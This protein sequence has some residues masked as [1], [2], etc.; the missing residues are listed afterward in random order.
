MHLND[1]GVAEKKEVWSNGFLVVEEY[2]DK[3][4][5]RMVKEEK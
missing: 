4:R 5:E 2:Y 1:K 3:V